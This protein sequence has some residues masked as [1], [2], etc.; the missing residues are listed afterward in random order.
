MARCSGSFARAVMLLAMVSCTR[1]GPAVGPSASTP[2]FRRGPRSVTASLARWRLPQARSRSVALEMND[3]V[4]LVGGLDTS[5]ASTTTTFVTDP[6]TGTVSSGVAL[7]RASHDAA[8]AVIGDAAFV[9]GGGASRTT[10]DVQEVTASGSALVARLPRPRSDSAVARIGNEVF[11]VGG[12]DGTHLLRALV[13]TADGAHFRSFGSLAVPVR[14]AAVAAADGALYVF[15]GST[16]SG[17]TDAVQRVDTSTGAASIVAH[18]PQRLSHAA[19]L[20]RGDSIFVF[21]GRVRGACSARVLLFDP[22]AHSV[23]RA[24]TLP[25]PLSDAAAVQYGDQMLL[26]G[27]ET[28][29]RTALVVVVE[30]R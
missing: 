27:G 7:R 21:G 26:I 24:G 19:A 2:P 13:E 8:G 18:L 1:S 12:Y 29:K 6:R 15:G 11:I 28:P 20:T 16:P 17:D 3:Q 22:A 14:Y 25:E 9:F 30:P 5:G 23:A 10:A 4:L